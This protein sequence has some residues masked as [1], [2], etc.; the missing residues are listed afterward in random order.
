MPRPMPRCVW[1]CSSRK[2]TWAAPPSASASPIAGCR[3]GARVSD[4]AEQ[5]AAEDL[6]LV[7]RP[8]SEETDLLQLELRMEPGTVGAEEDLAGAGAPHRLDDEIES[9]HV[10]SVG[11]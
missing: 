4:E 10:G 2:G 6:R 9:L 3:S 5:I 8:Q 11:M 1:R 7:L